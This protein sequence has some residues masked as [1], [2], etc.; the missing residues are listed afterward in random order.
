MFSENSGVL[1]F[2]ESLASKF[3]SEN[4]FD[5]DEGRTP[6]ERLNNGLGV[7]FWVFGEKTEY[8]PKKKEVKTIRSI[9]S[10]TSV[11]RSESPDSVAFVKEEKEEPE[12]DAKI[13]DETLSVPILKSDW[14]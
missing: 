4:E 10:K 3:L 6:I 1:Q 9:K 7:S 12:K 13:L 11:K 5:E 14:N 8:M 2:W